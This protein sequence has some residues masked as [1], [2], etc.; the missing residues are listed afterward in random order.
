[1]LRVAHVISTVEG[2]AGAERIA[3]ALV[4]AASR[5]GDD[6]LLLN[7]FAR[8]PDGSILRREVGDLYR[9]RPGSRIRDLPSLRSWLQQE[10]T[11]FRPDIVHA[12]L[13][14]AAALV[15]STRPT[16]PRVLSHH[17]GAAL[18]YLRRPI[19]SE[20][21]KRSGARFDKIVAVSRSVERFLLEAYG[22]SRDHVVVIQN[23]WERGAAAAAESAV[24]VPHLVV[25]PAHLRP[26]KGHEVLLEALVRVR[27]KVPDVRLALL[28]GGPL[29]SHLQSTIRTLELDDVV[30]L[31]GPVAD[32]WSWYAKAAMVVVP[33]LYEALGLA[34]LEAMAAGLPVVAA[35]VGGLPEVVL[36]GE[37]G[38]LF[39]PGNPAS[40]AVAISDLL[41]SPARRGRMGEA[42]RERAKLFSME[43]MTD[44]YLA[45]YDRTARASR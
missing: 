35:R 16:A 27:R 17:H 33:S 18:R 6:V 4:R 31:V 1:M 9:G 42:G 38:L 39:D 21:D 25:C 44:S 43:K 23:G 15:A 7:P 34:A 3:S 20:I 10:I 2:L 19:A 13:F 36:H 37:T 41:A 24:R 29:Q 32:V 12:H 5:R 22:Y 40:L 11:G 30:T 45:L 26:E 8:D 28:G 14:H